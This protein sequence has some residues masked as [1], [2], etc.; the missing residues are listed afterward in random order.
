MWRKKNNWNNKDSRL[1][2]H[3]RYSIQNMLK[4]QEIHGILSQS[5]WWRVSVAGSM[6]FS[7]SEME[8]FNNLKNI[9]NNRSSYRVEDI[10]IMLEDPRGSIITVTY[11]AQ[12]KIPEKSGQQ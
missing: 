4:D 7:Y 1:N 6:G 11:S 10:S 9:L 3:R 5:A 2:L 12:K 8:I